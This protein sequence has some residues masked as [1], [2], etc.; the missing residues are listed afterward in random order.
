M[1]GVAVA[2]VFFLTLGVLTWLRLVPASVIAIY[3]FASVVAFAV[4]GRDKAAAQSGRRRTPESALLLIS[5]LCGWP[6]ALSARHVF[7]HKTRKQPFRT[8]FW[9]TVAANCA[10]LAFI[11][12]QS[13][14]GPG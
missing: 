9:C 6:G 5:V 3:A 10:V 1:K 8:L 2:V 13:A 4:Y 7:R 11:V 12:S 14:P